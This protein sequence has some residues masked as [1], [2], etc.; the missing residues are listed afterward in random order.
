M[1]SQLL[2]LPIMA[3]F[4]QGTTAAPAAADDGC[5][6]MARHQGYV[7]NCTATYTVASG[8]QC[9][10]IRDQFNNFTL[11]EFYAWNPEVDSACSNLYPG[12]RVCIG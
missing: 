6:L 9:G 8:D 4:T 11:E 12:E 10:A 5:N 7:E 3:V 2:L 1:V